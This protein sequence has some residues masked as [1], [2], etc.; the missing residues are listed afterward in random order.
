MSRS[1]NM[2]VDVSGLTSYLDELA[3]E[4]GHASRP[5]AQAAAQVFYDLAK[6]NV[7]RIGK[8]TGNLA[9]SIYQKFAVEE[10]QE[11]VSASYKVSWNVHTG[12]QITR[13]PH[14]HL[15]E[16]GHIQR[17]RV[18]IATKGKRKG[19]WVTLKSQPITPKQVGARPFMR[20]AYYAGKEAALAAAAAV[21]NE[22]IDKVK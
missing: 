2:G 7:G 21:I 19:Q 4:V 12:K 5:A 13:A 11:G 17:Y 3:V 16:Y 9:G 18:V 22:R 15:V 20:P 14:G 10:S 1:F 8:K 6:A